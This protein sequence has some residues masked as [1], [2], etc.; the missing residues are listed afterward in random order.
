MKYH[1]GRHYRWGKTCS[2]ILQEQDNC[3]SKLSPRV[4][5]KPSGV[6]RKV[7]VNSWDAATHYYLLTVAMASCDTIKVKPCQN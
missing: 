1:D 3:Q 6:T 7:V 2:D 5:N 4:S